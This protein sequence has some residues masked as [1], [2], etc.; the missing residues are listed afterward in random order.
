MGAEETRKCSAMLYKV[1][2]TTRTSPK[3]CKSTSF[4]GW[5]DNSRLENV[6]GR[7]EQVLSISIQQLL[8]HTFFRSWLSPGPTSP[9]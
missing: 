2:I 9:P 6:I 1:M 7:T 5:Y 3:T 8:H 4:M